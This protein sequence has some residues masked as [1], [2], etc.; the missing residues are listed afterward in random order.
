MDDERQ[1]LLRFKHSLIDEAD[2]LASWFGHVH[3]IH[4]PG[5]CSYDYYMI[6]EYEEF[7]S[8]RLKGDISPS[9][10]N[11]KQP[12]HLDL[13]CND[14]KG[15]Q[16]PSFMGSLGNLKYLNLSRSRFVGTIPPQLGNLRELGVLCL[17]RFYDAYTDEHEFTSIEN[18]QWLSS[19]RLLRHLDMSGV[20]LTKATDWLQL[21]QLIN[22][23]HLQLGNNR[24][25]GPIPDS[26]GRLSLLRSLDLDENL[27]SGSSPYSVGGLLSLELLDLSNNQLIDTLPESLGQLSKLNTLDLSNNL[28]TGV[29]TDSHFSKLMGLKY[30]NGRGNNLTLRPRCANWIPSFQLQSMYLSSWDLGPQFPS[31]LLTQRDLIVLEIRN[32]RVS[33]TMPKSFWKSF[34]NLQSLVMSQNQMQGRLFDIPATLRLVDLSSNLFSGNLPE[35]CNVSLLIILDLSNNSFTGSLHNFLCPYGGKWLEALNLANNHLSGVIP[36]CWVNWPSLVFLNLENN[37]L[38]GRIPTTLESLSSLESLNMGKNKLSGELPI[39]LKKLTKLKI[40]QFATNELVGSIPAWIGTDLSSLRILN[41]QSNNF[42]GNITHELCY[43]T[44]IQI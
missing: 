35:L 6:K 19:L 17:G 3:E 20:N 14:F 30:L 37:N 38:S 12:Q 15:I 42:D 8:Q 16:I 11:L 24:I 40:L 27:I 5:K 1:A 22:L 28:L 7:I 21:G 34:P 9:I 29:V 13:S 10:L 26:I 36:E 18:M 44:F 39:S 32:A 2:R 25:A 4:L 43:L 33:S 31:W 23:V 41:L